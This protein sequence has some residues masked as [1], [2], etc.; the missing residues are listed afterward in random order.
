MLVSRISASTAG[1]CVLIATAFAMVAS[2]RADIRGAST[3]RPAAQPASIAFGIWWP[4]FALGCAHG[5]RMLT[6]EATNDDDAN[7][8]QSLASVLYAFA[9]VACGA[10]ALIIGPSAWRR[11]VAAGLIFLGACT[12]TVALGALRLYADPRTRCLTSDRLWL[13]EL[14]ISLLAGWLQVAFVIA[15][16]LALGEDSLVNRQPL[17]SLAGVAAVTIIVSFVTS[18]AFLVY[19]LIWATVLSVNQPRVARVALAAAG[20]VTHVLILRS[21]EKK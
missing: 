8:S 12:S 1:T 17:A 16:A 20:V 21:C 6:L 19:P 3:F 15:L 7:A 18:S 4:I 2:A 13:H 14:P 11:N 9:F 5:I 10:W